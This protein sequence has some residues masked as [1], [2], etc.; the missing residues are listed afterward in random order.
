MLLIYVLKALY[1]YT[2]YFSIFPPVSFISLP[3]D[4]FF[5]STSPSITHDFLKEPLN[6]IR[7]VD[8]AIGVVLLAGTWPP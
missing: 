2:I 1:V 7:V 3:L 6:L 8:M 4:P 5:F